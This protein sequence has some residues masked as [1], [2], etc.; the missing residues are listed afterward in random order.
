MTALAAGGHDGFE[1]STVNPRRAW[2]AR[3][4]AV[5]ALLSLAAPHAWAWG[6]Q[7]HR[8]IG[9]IADRLLA[10]TPAEPKLRALLQPGETLAQ[11]ATWAD[12]VK[13]PRVCNAALTPEMNAFVQAN[14]LHREYHYTDTNIG[15]DGYHAGAPGTSDHD[16]VQVLLQC[17]QVLRGNT[18]PD[19]NPHGFTQRQALLLV[20]H[21]MG[22]LEQPLHVGAIYLDD[23]GDAVEPGDQA[24]ALATTNDGG[25][26]LHVE[27][28]D[29]RLLHGVWDFDV[30]KAAFARASATSADD[31]AARL[32]RA[33]P[34]PVVSNDPDR[35]ILAWT[36]ESLRVSRMVLR[37]LHY[38]PRHVD[39]GHDGERADGWD[40]ALP[41]GYEAAQAS[42]V[43]QRLT[44]GGKRLAALLQATLPPAKDKRRP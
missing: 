27:G 43:Q 32:L 3:I 5:L 36:N 35:D 22:D 34:R 25:N 10:G 14:P 31:M 39:S 20:V 2:H 33:D 30:V 19:I 38:S 11:V 9:A 26:K 8:A 24:E 21:L 12:C 7:G 4:A 17:V 1:E 42:L 41:P 37:G 6:P 15:A 40:V 44:L 23:H 18:G 16:I 13:G 28:D 29:A